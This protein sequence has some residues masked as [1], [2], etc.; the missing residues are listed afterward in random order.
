MLRAGA[1]VAVVGSS[2]AALVSGYD[3]MTVLFESN[4]LFSLSLHDGHDDLV[5]YADLAKRSIRSFSQD[6]IP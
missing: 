3:P 5:Q 1:G 4:P 2:V 6:K